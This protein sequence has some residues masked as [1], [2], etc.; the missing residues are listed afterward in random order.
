MIKILYFAS[1]REA[2]G[3]SEETFA[4]DE[5][6]VAALLDLLRARGG[7]YAEALDARKR[8]R[9]AINQD[10]ATLDSR[11]RHGDE[12]AIFPPVTGG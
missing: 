1:L 7:A 3:V 2:L 4:L 9:V 6:N 5:S 11:I 12:V 10:M 8:F